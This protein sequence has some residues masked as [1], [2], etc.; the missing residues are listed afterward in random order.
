VSCEI[1][2]CHLAMKKDDVF[3]EMSVIPLRA[4]RYSKT[5][6]CLL[7]HIQITILKGDLIF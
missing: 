6:F 5:Q 7:I 2:E 1:A 4:C 3:G